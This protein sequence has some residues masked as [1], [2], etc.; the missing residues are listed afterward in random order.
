VAVALTPD[1][2]KRLA[3]VKQVNPETYEAYLRGMYLVQQATKEEMNLGISLLKEAVAKN[4]DDALAW[5][6]LALAWNSIGHGPSSR[7][8]ALPNGKA[9]ALKAIELDDTLAEAHAALGES[10]IYYDWDWEGSERAYKRALELNP[11]LAIAHAHYAF[12][13]ALFGRWEEAIEQEMHAH[14]LDPR[15]PVWTVF[16]GYLTYYGGYPEEAL[17]WTEVGSAIN[18]DF[19][20]NNYLKGLL[21]SLEGRF[22]ES[23]ASHRRA[24]AATSNF[25]WGL[26][27]ALAMAGQEEEA[28]ELL[29]ELTQAEIPDTWA[30]ALIYIELGDHDEAFKW[31]EV[32]YDQRRDWIPWIGVDSAFAALWD[33]PRMNDLL[34]RM[35]LPHDAD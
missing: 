11:N 8:E 18:D 5:A 29:A 15:N 19:P 2:E 33:D 25:G 16:L 27:H 17:K 9:A 34:R 23:I 4:P 12:H 13:H 14:K 30:I 26:P 7:S 21:F 20:F 22:E 1:E 3:Q 32:G 24:K 6:G 28:R 35:N 10:L 31:L